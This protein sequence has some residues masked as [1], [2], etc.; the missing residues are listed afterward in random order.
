VTP[1]I[2]RL[3]I[4]AILGAPLTLCSLAIERVTAAARNGGS[5]ELSA[6]DAGRDPA[7]LVNRSQNQ[8]M[9][10]P[11]IKRSVSAQRGG[12]APPRKPAGTRLPSSHP[13][14]SPW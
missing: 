1:S 11:A 14:V 9:Y 12:S 6:V 3:M 13:S 7:R 5:G 8:V 10:P 4:A 2:L